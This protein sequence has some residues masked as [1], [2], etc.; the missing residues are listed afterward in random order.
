MIKLDDFSA[1]ILMDSPKYRNRCEVENNE[2][3]EL[4]SLLQK[5]HLDNSTAGEL[6]RLRELLPLLDG[7]LAN[8]EKRIANANE[9]GK[10]PQVYTFETLKEFKVDDETISKTDKFNKGNVLLF[11]NPAKL[12]SVKRNRLSMLTVEEIKNRLGRL[13]LGKLDNAFVAS[14]RDFGHLSVPRL[15]NSINVYDK[16][17]TRVYRETGNRGRGVNLLEVDKREKQEIVRDNI[18]EMTELLID[19]GTEYVWGE[20]SDADKLKMYR[21]VTGSRGCESLKIYENLLSMFTNYTTLNQLKQGA[22]KPK[23]LRKFIVK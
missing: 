19:S 8:A 7:K 9:K 12:Y 15:V 5:Y 4:Y 13:D 23:T 1:K 2:L 3:H 16:Q 20:L 14:V 21:A 18:R 6:K 11:N 10:N 22:T 17:L